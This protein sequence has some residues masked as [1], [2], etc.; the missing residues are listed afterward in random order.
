MN[1]LVKPGLEDDWKNNILPKFF[2]TDPTSVD[3]CRQP[4]LF[5]EEATVNFGSM[6]ALRNTFT[7]FVYL[8]VLNFTFMLVNI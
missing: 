8:Y 2:V 3:Q 1:D 5:K 7:I 6:V 4:G